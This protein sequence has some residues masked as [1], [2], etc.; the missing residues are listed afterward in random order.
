MENQALLFGDIGNSFLTK[1]ERREQIMIDLGIAIPEK[2]RKPEVRIERSEQFDLNLFLVEFANEAE[3]E[4]AFKRWD[5]SNQDLA[6]AHEQ[7]LIVFLEDLRDTRVKE[8]RLMEWLL[9]VEGPEDESDTLEP[10]SFEACCQVF[11]CDPDDLR[12]RIAWLLR[13]RR[14]M[15][16]HWTERLQ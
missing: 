2:V 12:H 16:I 9:W 8:A 11:G 6:T 10:F 3:E 7:F 13:N 15:N 4:Q 1:K 14:N 5:W